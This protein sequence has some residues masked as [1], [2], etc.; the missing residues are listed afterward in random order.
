M[1]DKYLKNKIK[2]NDPKDTNIK[3]SDFYYTLLFIKNYFIKND[4]TIFICLPNLYDAQKYYDLLSELVGEEKVLFYPQDELL[5][6]LMALGSPEF[7]NERLYTLRNLITNKKYICVMQYEAYLRNQ[8]SPTKY[9][10]S[11]FKISKNDNISINKLN[12]ILINNGYQNNYTVEKPG[13]FSVRGGILD[14]FTTE[15]KYPYRIDFFGNTIEK[16]KVFDVKDQLSFDTVESFNIIPLNELFFKNSEI[17]NFLENINTYFKDKKLSSKEREKLNKDIENLKTRTNL[18]TLSIYIPFLN[19]KKTTIKDFSPNHTTIFINYNQILLNEERKKDDYN[20]YE[21]SMGGKS[22]LNINF[23]NN[24]DKL[25]KKT[26]LY[27]YTLPI[28]KIK[29]KENYHIE[30]INTYQ[31][32]LELFYLDNEN[33]FNNYTVILTFTSKQN[34]IKVDNFFKQL[35]LKV[36]INSI[37]ENQINLVNSNN[38]LNF[39]SHEDKLFL[40]SESHLIN[41]KYKSKIRYRSVLAQSTKIRNI[42]EIKPGDYVVHYD[43]GIGRYL[44]LKTISLENKKR[45][46]LHIQYAF[47]KVMYIPVSQIDLVLKYSAADSKVP[48]L[49]NL[50]S[51]TWKRTKTKVKKNIKE[52]ADKLLKL[53]ANREIIKGFSFKNYPEIENKLAESF[54]FILTTDQQKAISKVNKLMNC[55]RAMDL[56]LIGDVGFG[57]TEVA[58]RAAFKAVLNGKQVAYLVPT[59]I[60]ARQHYYTFKE[61]LEEFGIN[62]CLL[63]RFSSNK[64]I[65][66]DLKNLEIGTIDIAIGTHRLLSKD[67]KFKDLG[68]FIIDEEQRFGVTDKE[69]IRSIKVNIDTLTLTATP[70]P[71]TLQMSL[72][73]I[74]QMQ[75]IE[76]PPLNRYPVQ[77]YVI[78]RE[79]SIIREAISREIA[80]GGQV[81]YLFNRV[82]SMEKI[83]NNLNKLIPE[84]RISYIHGQMNKKDIEDTIENFIN[85]EYDVLVS[86]TII[87]T[88]IDIPNTNTLIVHDSDKLGLSQLYQ[89]K[90]RVGRIDKI[91]YAYLMYDPNKILNEDAVERLNAIEKNTSLGSGLKIAMQDLKIRGAGDLLGSE[92]SGFIDSVGMEMYLRL[93]NETITGKVKRPIQQGKTYA[94]EHISPDY[95]SDEAVRIEIHKNI[96]KLNHMKDVK[97]L[98]E[99][100][101]DRFG[102]V[103]YELELYMHEKL[104]I[105]QAAKLGVEKLKTG[106]K[107]ILK[108]KEDKSND[109]DGQSLFKVASNFII[110]VKIDYI[111]NQII[112]TFDF[113]NEKIEWLLV[114]NSFI[115]EYFDLINETINK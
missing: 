36:N 8:L 71:R 109:I 34:L 24:L 39:I 98:K 64:Q 10:N 5:T 79:K 49:S 19:N 37:K 104:Y 31:N 76:T 62:I 90:G 53:Y 42:D 66:K 106:K 94:N 108:L 40:I 14:I 54:P 96:S 92:Q 72:S 33:Y 45:D 55:N 46:Y 13:E 20:A 78:Q 32:N 80:R 47:N 12:E 26:D 21:I 22:F 50:N 44:G 103:S 101:N 93:L 1:I 7:K 110:P 95:I 35:N 86:T 115:S 9:L 70:I 97:F 28:D 89:I 63:S 113:T 107:T 81:F 87:E 84:A 56:L 11:I 43:Y 25:K 91:A 17:N 85:H 57:K 100:L 111:N 68:L 88:G 41:K 2:F 74:K 82:R 6:T 58:I 16:I 52:I 48:K 65:S 114:I 27:I 18:D 23:F 60:L 30:S 75:V 112:L 3:I 102:N 69:K 38:K 29:T 4:K 51:D 77:T 83:M 61:R 99:E 15:N 105:R 59:T 67:V 73:G